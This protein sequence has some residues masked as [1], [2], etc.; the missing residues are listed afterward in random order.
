MPT[1]HRIGNIKICMYS[2]DHNPPHFHVLTPDERGSVRIN[3][4]ELVAGSLSS[5][6]LKK[7]CEWVMKNRNELMDKWEELNG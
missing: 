7:S 5:E 3:D 2:D 4:L 1:L 6:V